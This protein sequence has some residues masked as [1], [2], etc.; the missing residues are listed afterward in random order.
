MAEN[1]GTS[2]KRTP[3]FRLEITGDNEFK[4]EIQEK[5]QKVKEYLT[6]MQT[7]P[8]NNATVLKTIL[9]YWINNNI[10]SG[11]GSHGPTQF[12]SSYLQVQRGDVDQK[13][14]ITAETSL[15]NF[16]KICET[17]KKLCKGSMKFQTKT[18]KGHVMSMA[19]QCDV[20][21]SHR[22]MWSSSPYLPNDEYLVNHRINHGLACSGMLPSHY[23]RFVNGS[24]IGCIEWS[25]RKDFVTSYKDCV[26]DAYQE[27]IQTALREEIASYEELDGI[28]IITDARHG[29]RKNAKDSSVVA[30]GENM[31]KVID[32]VHVTKGDDPISQRHE[33]FGTERIYETLQTQNVPIKVH[34][35]DRNLSINKLVKDTGYTV[36]QNDLWHAVKSLKKSIKNVSSG[37]KKTEDISWSSQLV[38][39]MEPV[40]THIHWAIRH[41]NKDP[42]N[43]RQIMD[44]IIPHYENVHNMCHDDSRCRKDENYEPSRIVLTSKMAKKLLEK[45]LKE[46]VIYKYP[47]DYI[48]G[49]DT[50]YVE[51]F[52]NVMNVFQDKRI[53]FG[54]EQ[55]KLRSNLAVC[56]WN[57]NVDREHTSVYTSQN[58]NAPRNQKGK[59]VY[60]KLTFTYRRNIWRKYM[61]SVFD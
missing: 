58:P 44:S 4:R 49:K 38:D 47:E 20:N 25:R 39:K 55:Y 36:N 34:A 11:S 33:K 26:E 15:K 23:T 43:L 46:S 51:S 61:D 14:F 31:H 59:K 6:P 52:N 54:D 45:A 57:E 53:A 3:F 5:F 27:S 37:T 18:M 22:Y 2:K 56:H 42:Q 32:C 40:A 9:D 35:H 50:F 7:K 29:W 12:P 24:G 19:L 30:I 16:G 21:K 10:N 48:L 8:A 28:N 17:H 13:L 1:Q 41:C 60:K